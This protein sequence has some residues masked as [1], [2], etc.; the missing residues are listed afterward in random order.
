MNIF[1][2]SCDK[3]RL[4]YVNC[5]FLMQQ[6]TISYELFD[7]GPGHHVLAQPNLII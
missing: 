3:M 6:T 4:I 7:L 2:G 1:I 5:C